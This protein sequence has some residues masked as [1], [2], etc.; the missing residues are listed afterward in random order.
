MPFTSRRASLVL[1]AETEKLLRELSRS[2]MAPAAQKERAEMLLAYAGGETISAIARQLGTNRPKVERCVQKALEVGARASLRDLP[3]SGRPERL[4]PEARTWVVS[5]ACRKPLELGYSYELWTTALLAKHVREHCM[6]AGHP[7]L[8][9]L[10]RG[11]VS[12]ILAHADIHPHRIEY[13]LERRDPLFDMKM[14]QVL[15]V[16]KQ[17]QLLRESGA[18][19]SSLIAYLSYD[20]KP[21]IQA[22]ANLAPDLP[23]VPGRHE[24]IARDH[25]YKRNGTVTLMAAI[26]LRDGRVHH[27]IVE[28]H[29]GKEFV[30]FLQQRSAAYPAEKKIRMIL[31]NHSAHI[32]RETRAYLATVPNRFEFVFTPTHGSWLNLIESMFGKMARTV[33]RGLRVKSKDELRERFGKYFDEI[34][35]DPVI[36][37]WKYRMEELSVA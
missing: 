3:R 26:D 25:Q 21:G 16:Y 19:G 13:Y 37:H 20:E 24:S 28:R 32:S 35:R 27:Q 14:I 33:L 29:R 4:T 11:T 36:F 17:I 31:D 7:S 22:I 2:R 1:D 8:A 10:G 18:A 5:L 9:R 23:P 12:K 34:N 15:C 6:E 30:A